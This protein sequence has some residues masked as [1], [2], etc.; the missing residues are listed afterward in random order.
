[1]K[2]AVIKIAGADAI[3]T[4]DHYRSR[5][6]VTGQYPFLIGDHKDLESL[7][8]KAETNDLDPKAIIR[9]ALEINTCEWIATRRRAERDFS[10]DELF[11]EW[12]GELHEK[13]SIGIHIEID[14]PATVERQWKVI[15]RKIKP[16]VYLGL[17]SIE[18]PW[19]L[20]AVVKYGGVA[21]LP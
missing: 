21:V 2:F 13:G 18:L 19:H 16:E 8:E 14:V 15:T 12:P 1:M 3:R 4:L 11:G 5:Y 17:A 7:Q 9:E 10:A 20:P 6:G